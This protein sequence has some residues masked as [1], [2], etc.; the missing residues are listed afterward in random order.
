MQEL[1]RCFHGVPKSITRNVHMCCRYPDRLAD[2]NYK[3][4]DPLS[5]HKR[6]FSTE[7]I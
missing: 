7:E 3:K 4:A 6:S 5:F 1:E 2:V